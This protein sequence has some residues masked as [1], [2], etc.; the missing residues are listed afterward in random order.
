MLC[1]FCK[2]GGKAQDSTFLITTSSF[3]T[4]INQSVTT[5][6]ATSLQAPTT[7]IPSTTS[8]Q[9][10]APSEVS[11]NTAIS[12][13]PKVKPVSKKDGKGNIR[14]SGSVL[15]QNQMVSIYNNLVSF[16]VTKLILVDDIEE[17]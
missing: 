2:I 16:V 13:R 11:Q 14:K 8:T 5:T 7:A 17:G 10:T 15:Q 9:I 6:T 4:S 12:D 3:P 1:I